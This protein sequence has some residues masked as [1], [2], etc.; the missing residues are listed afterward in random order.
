MLFFL[1]SIDKT[2]NMLYNYGTFHIAKE[3]RIYYYDEER[4]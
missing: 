2:N 4:K 3:S 1:L